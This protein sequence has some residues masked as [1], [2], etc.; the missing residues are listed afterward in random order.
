MK[1]TTELEKS[2]SG[3]FDHQTVYCKHTNNFILQ[4]PLY[5]IGNEYLKALHLRFNLLPCLPY[6]PHADRFCRSVCGN[7]DTTIKD[8]I[9]QHNFIAKRISDHAKSSGWI[10]KKEPHIKCTDNRYLIPDLILSKEKT[11][12]NKRCSYTVGKTNKKLIEGYLHKESI[13]SNEPFIN[14]IKMLYP[15]CTIDVL[16]SL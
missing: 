11:Y 13:Y 5:W 9:E 8:R 16:P 6:I 12:N 3:G 4:P 1:S 2:F 10:V 7:K 15:N 14:K